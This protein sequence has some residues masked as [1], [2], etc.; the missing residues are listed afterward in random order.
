MLH[1]LRTLGDLLGGPI[2]HDVLMATDLVVVDLNPQT[3]Q[4]R[5]VTLQKFETEYAKKCLYVR[6]DA[7]KTPIVPTIRIANKGDI[8]R[9]DGIHL[10]K[11][12]AE[13]LRRSVNNLSNHLGFSIDAD[14]VIRK[15]EE[16]VS[17]NFSPKMEVWAATLT[18]EGKFMEDVPR[19]KEYFKKQRAKRGRKSQRKGVCA[20][21]GEEK[22]VSGDIS[23]FKFYTID[24]P[25]YVVGGFDKALAYK[26]FPLC[27]D[28]RDL[29]QRG[30]QHVEANLTFDFVSRRIR[31]LLIPDFIFGSQAVRQD[32]LEILT[33]EREQRQGRLHTLSRK[34]LKRITS[35][36]GDIL[37]L[38]SEERDVMT[39]HFLFMSRQQGREAI[40]LY[41]QDV[42]PS[43]LRALLRAK[44]AV[45]RAL[46]IP[47]EDGTWRDYDFTY[48]TLYRFF[49]KADPNKRNPDLLRHFYDLVD[50]TFRAAPVS[51]NYLIP[52]LMAQIRHGVATPDR[53]DQG[54][55]RF[56]ILDA[57]ASLMFILFTTRKEEPMSAQTPPTLEAYLESLPALEDDLKKGLFLLGALTERLLQVQAKE[58]KSAPFWKSLKS[59]KMNATDF[60]GLLPKVR[61][62]LQEYDRFGRGEATLFQLASA[63]LAQ[64]K[65][66][67]KMSVDE[68]NFYFALGMGL[69]PQV[70]PY[71]YPPQDESQ[72]KEVEA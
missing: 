12:L 7:N 36:E 16:C 64:T 37:D 8:E 54:L 65:I 31:Y 33:E 27:Y 15:V 47:R 6:H 62:K 41:I 52:F 69:F 11:S 18:F 45:D 50:R 70:A 44:A 19:I 38:L 25:G 28:C 39:F 60:Q 67:W 3:G 17:E 61:N 68:L 24:K 66:P 26:A 34:E 72:Q 48:A 4:I 22:E 21:C 42:Y 55:Y 59:L 71:I 2:Q 51:A 53:R 32:V 40:D 43:R 63:Y 23:P 46:R 14:E 10:K 13:K 30:R 9:G 49:S 57:L 29:I 58:R 20:V 1:A 5:E 35:D 56:T